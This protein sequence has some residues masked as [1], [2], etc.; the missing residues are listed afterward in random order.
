MPRSWD[1]LAIDKSIV[2]ETF[3][4]VGML[5]MLLA[6]ALVWSVT[7]IMLDLSM[8]VSI[9]GGAAIGALAGWVVAAWEVK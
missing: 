7:V 8:L 6:V 2:G 5:I 1:D 9:V 3:K 4:G